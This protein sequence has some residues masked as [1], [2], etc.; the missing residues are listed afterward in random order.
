MHFFSGCIASILAQD[1]VDFDILIYD[2]A[3]DQLNVADEMKKSFDDP[4]IEYQ[5][6]EKILGV[7]P[8]RDYIL[9]QK[10]SPILIGMD[11][12]AFLVG[13]NALSKIVAH[14]DKNPEHALLVPRIIDRH[15][16]QEFDLVPFSR[17][18]ISSDPVLTSRPQKVSYYVGPC[19][20]ARQKIIDAIGYLSLTTPYGE[21]EVDISYKLVRAGH[22]L[23]YRPDIVAIH[24]PVRVLTKRPVNLRSHIQNR[25]YLAWQYLPMPYT[26]TYIL[27]WLAFY[28][29]QALRRP[30]TGL[31]DMYRSFL[32]AVK[33]RH[34]YKRQPLGPQA[35]AYLKAYNGRLWF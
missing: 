31:M 24:E 11:D 1:Y 3:S 16:D 25:V 21:D 5:R 28:T 6:G 15:G 10:K 20:A 12:D 35:I 23:Y 26:L 17:R 18:A 27:T 22:T 34:Q 14:F 30:S 29:Y 2:D 9:R 32:H 7:T 4:R 8:A 33:N 19:Y 13:E